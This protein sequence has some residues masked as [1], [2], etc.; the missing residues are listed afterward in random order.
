METF[1]IIHSETL[2][3]SYTSVHVSIIFFITFSENEIIKAKQIRHHR[4]KIKMPK[5]EENN[6]HMYNICHIT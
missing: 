5:R 2:H 4:V 1:E 6:I 3:E